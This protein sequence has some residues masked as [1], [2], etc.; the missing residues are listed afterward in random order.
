M[1]DSGRTPWVDGLTFGQV[2]AETTRRHA[3]REAMVFPQ[4]ARRWTWQQFA[5]DVDA[6]ARGLL[7]LGIQRGEHVAIWATNVPEWV[8]L[9]FAAARIGAVLVNI[10]PAYRPYELD[11]VL[12][13]SDSVALFLVDQ[14][15]SSDY[16]SMLAEICPEIAQAKDG[17]I[18]SPRFPK[19]RT[20]VALKGKPPAGIP[21]WQAMVAG[22]EKVPQQQLGEL[23]RQLKPGDAINIQYTSGTTG[24]PKAATLSHRNLLLNAFY[25]GECQR[26]SEQDRICIPV[27]FYHCFGCVLGTLACAVYGSAMIVPAEYFQA[28]PTLDAIER[29]GATS[30]YG[31]PTMFIA[32]L[33][34]PSLPSRTITTLRTGIM[35][36]APCPIEVMRQVGDKLGATEM[37]I[38]YGQTE[39]SPV[40]TQTRTDDPIE[41]RVET[42]GRATPGIEVKIV[43]P[44]SG[45]S[46]SDNEQG[47]FCCRGHAVMIGYYKNPEATAAAIDKEGWLHTGDLAVRLPNGY[48]KITGRLKDMVIRGGENIY[49]REIEEFLFT[50]PAVEQAAVVG[51][52]DAK[53]GEELCVWIKLKAGQQTTADAIREFC[54][55]KLAHYKVPRYVKFVESF[56]QTVT[57]KIQKFKIRD[58]MKEE[59]GLTEQKTA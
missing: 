16:F 3:N 25:I 45:N 29:E 20:I 30:L 59:L 1:A 37:T 35:A 32:Q 54:R 8:L 26:L 40:V 36:G 38:A 15:K 52:P 27:P 24:F 23:D 55:A 19:L 53:Y 28:A 33:Q 21:L 22:G 51:V 4:L 57:G 31:V 41:L 50:H 43:D 14:F 7:A 2:L 48:Y 34:D 9:Q 56:P 17:R 49:P 6:A 12:K 44:A 11:Y 58:L 42:V 10:N 13:Q 39:A 5:D 18:N 47:E 46:L